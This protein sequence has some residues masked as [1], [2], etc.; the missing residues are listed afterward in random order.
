L[1][2]LD[3]WPDTEETPLAQAFADAE[4]ASARRIV[5]AT[6][7]D[8][9]WQ[10][11]LREKYP[12]AV[13]APFA[14]RHVRLWEWV[15][16][17]TPGIKPTPLVEGWPRGGAKSSTAEM[18]VTRIGANVRHWPG[19]PEPRPARRFVL[20]I[21]ETQGQADKHVQAIAGKF[22]GIGVGRAVSKYGQSQGWRADLLRTDTGFNVLALGLDAAG[23]GV[24]IEDFRPDLF[25][26]DD[27]DNRHDTEQAV[28]KKKETITQ[29]ILPAGA[30]DAAVLFVQNRIHSGGIVSQLLD[31]TA[32][33][34]YNREAHEE[35]AV[36]GLEYD[37]EIQGDGKRRYW[38]TAGTPT[39]E[40]QPLSLCEQQ[41][42]EWGRPAFMREAQHDMD[43]A[44]DGLWQRDRDIDPFRC[45][46]VGSRA[47]RYLGSVYP[48]VR[49]VVG[50]DPNATEG[51]DEAG[52][53]V[54][55]LFRIGG[56]D[57]AGLLEDATTSGGPATWAKEA[58]A[59]YVRWDADALV[60]ESNN[61]G[62][63]VAITIGTVPGA[64]RVKLLHASRGKLT[65]AEPVQK[66]A[67]DGRAH[68][69]GIFNAL[70]KELCTWT[71]GDPS[72]NRL[73]A[74]VW[75]ATELM[76]TPKPRRIAPVPSRSRYA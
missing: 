12:S 30:P 37:S 44:E 62:D 67:E 14:A 49:I 2:L 40:G 68:H 7:Y 42:M 18:G 17:L 4:R 19:E 3:V 24:K 74:W 72:P 57:H 45:A 34:L 48:I 23:R 26:F 6:P 21:S 70:E 52:I 15:E 1:T 63:M 10:R 51:N 33:F 8:P 59:A 71:P 25:I 47:V 13:R 20:Y 5:S 29:N 60:A 75:C 65:R 58:V 73:D 39:W 46:V 38:I 50:V 53:V 43:E 28:K 64:P 69:A 36:L 32:D 35:P 41:M 9:D 66:L 16:A 76:L 11:W 56:V 54:G 27:I 55:G 61:G 22:S 31:G